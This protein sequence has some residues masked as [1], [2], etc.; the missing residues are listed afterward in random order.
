M[1][2]YDW[3]AMLTRRRFLGTAGA[4]L[5][6]PLVAEAQKPAKPA[7]I[8]YLLTGALESPETRA[9]LDAFRQGLRERGYVEGQNVV[10]EYR[11]AE[12]RIERFPE[13]A[14]ELIRLE[15]DLIVAGTTP[16][17]RGA[18]QATTT[19]PIVAFAMG[20][21]VGDGLVASLGRPGGNVTG[22]TFL[23]PQ[24]VPKRLEL[25]KELLPR[26]ARVGAL[27][28]PG[29]FA[30]RTMNEMW[31]ETE[32]AART[33]G[34]Q[35]LPVEARGPDEL[36]GAF[37]KMAG[38]RVEAVLL[39]PSTMLFN[40]RRRLIALAARF[41]LPAMFNAREF[42]ELGGLIGYGA[43]LADLTRRSGMYVEKILKGA[44]PAD[45]PVEQ[46]TKFDLTINMKTAKALGLTIPPAMLARA[47][48]VIE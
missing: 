48:H 15:I 6:A 25:L 43:S 20:D 47:D 35:L 16:A 7:R 8:G 23:G 24:L 45:L 17:A 32:A 33:L 14:R 2:L 42:V 19:V 4:S 28:Q 29:A 10:I 31:K 3:T 41:R 37:S 5:L 30:E 26:V 9:A 27:W 46:P 44:K 38:S 34:V 1:L 22:L 11:T 39:F 40:E 36:E 13:L 18:R 21:P 12:G